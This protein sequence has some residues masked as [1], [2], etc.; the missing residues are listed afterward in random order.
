MDMLEHVHIRVTF[1]FFLYSAT[2]ASFL[3]SVNIE[4]LVGW[5]SY[6]VNIERLVGWFLHSV[7]IEKLVSDFP[8][9]LI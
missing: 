9:Q 7:N 5:F 8:I 2:I 3:D 1:S 4:R 6:T